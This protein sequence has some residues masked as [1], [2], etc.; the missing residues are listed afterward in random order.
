MDADN[1]R[2]PPEP[3]DPGQNNPDSV[4]RKDQAGGLQPASPVSGTS[5]SI[6]TR[7]FGLALG[8][9]VLAILIVLAVSANS[10]SRVIGEAG[11][12]STRSLRSQIEAYL[13]QVNQSMAVQSALI[14]DRSVRDVQTVADATGAIYNGDIPLASAGTELTVGPEGQAMNEVDSISSLFVPNLIRT[15]A[16]SDAALAQAIQRDLDIS[17]NLDLTLKS[18]KE[19]N[20]N[21]SALYL[22][23]A[24][25]VLRY[26]PN[27]QIGAVVPADFSVTQRPWYISSLEKNPSHMVSKPVWSPVYFDATGLG[28][29]TTIA[30]PVYTRQGELVGVVGLDITLG[31]LQANIEN[32][33]FLQTGYSFLI[34]GQGNALI[35]PEQG[36]NDLLGTAPD[37]DN[38]TPN[39]RGLLAEQGNVNRDLE[40]I[41]NNMQRGESGFEMLTLGGREL[42][43][44]YSPVRLAETSLGA[45][46]SALGPGWSLASIVPAEEV[47]AEVVTL[48]DELVK[49]SQGIIFG[50]IL[51]IGILIALIAVALAWVGANRLVKPI[52][53]LAAAAELLG[54]GEWDQS[55][56][57]LKEV[58]AHNPD[59]IGLLAGTLAGMAEQLKQTIGQL[60]QRVAERTQQLEY[61]SLQLQ[62]AAEIARDITLSPDLETL[63]QGAVD[64][65]GE[66]FG[67]YNVGIFL[68]DELGEYAQLKV[69][70]GE[71][72]ARLRQQAIRLRVGQQ[73]MVGYVTRFG[74]PRLSDD[75]QL[76]QLYVAEPLLADTRSELTLP[77]RSGPKIIGALDVQSRQPAAFTQDDLNALQTLANQLATA[78]ENV[79][80]VTQVQSALKET[81]QL[82]QNQ[83]RQSWD[84]LI[85]D[86]GLLAYEYDLLEVRP[87][88]QSVELAQVD[89]AAPDQLQE[90]RPGY[91]K[92]PVRLRDEVIGTIVLESQDPDHV[93]SQDE[94]SVVEATASQAGLTVENARLLAESQRRAQREQLAAEVTGRLRAS[95]DM[96]TVLQTAVRE[97][98]QRLGIAQVEV[99]LG[100]AAYSP[101]EGLNADATD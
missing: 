100:G 97:I 58:Q 20:P 14:L 16:E 81:N 75:V 49:T 31:E 13:V 68:V 72:G 54:A 63:L 35:L 11:D 82:I 2:I 29:V 90:D 78:I 30:E 92:V 87:V 34:D 66:R 18:I 3:S 48:Q 17:G 61:R 56:P 47:L 46:G 7:L 80:L 84:R 69:A 91:L 24:H 27:I 73:G 42:F 32:A 26:Y 77:L 25:D 101:A 65:I 41:L 98:S 1:Q 4:P 67:F 39:L 51:P 60:E 8:L 85:A 89:Q 96:E 94:I 10:A 93:W 23:T 40:R 79:R 45:T 50:R 5:L 44:A 43:L 59:E 12:T 88:S 57:A 55:T 99:Q 19:N 53:K 95:L 70:S 9:T 28:L 22:G 64:L 37:A 62:T 86:Q 33:R 21:A 76:D 83:T 6:R 36:Y 52:R 15:K 71:L 74:Q 38:P